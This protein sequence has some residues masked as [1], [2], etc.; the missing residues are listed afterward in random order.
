[1]VLPESEYGNVETVRWQH[2]EERLG[3]GWVAEKLRE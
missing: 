3:E 2:R 1:L